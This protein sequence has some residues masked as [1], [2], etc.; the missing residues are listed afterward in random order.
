M[1]SPAAR[2]SA[3][4]AITVI[5]LLISWVSSRRNR[6]RASS[7][8][9]SSSSRRRSR[10]VAWALAIAR[11]RSWPSSRAATPSPSVQRREP[12]RRAAISMPSTS[13]STPTGATTTASKPASSS[14]WANQSACAASSTGSP[15]MRSGSM[16]RTRWSAQAR[17]AAASSAWRTSGAICRPRLSGVST[18]SSRK[19]WISSSS[20]DSA[21]SSVPRA[22]RSRW[23]TSWRAG[24]ERASRRV[25]RMTRMWS[26]N[27]SRSTAV[28]TERRVIASS[29]EISSSRSLSGR[30][31]SAGT[32]R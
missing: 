3:F 15:Q 14:A 6:C 1:C 11:P 16:M 20:T 30:L 25:A 4:A 8:S 23:W 28:T 19:T 9:R 5:G 31:R 10:C 2:N 13:S 21:P 12:V 24:L 22:S 29:S 26:A 32:S 7:S 17:A 27:S 18:P